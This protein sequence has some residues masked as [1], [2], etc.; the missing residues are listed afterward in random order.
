MGWPLH[1]IRLSSEPRLCKLGR[2]VPVIGTGPNRMHADRGVL[3][4]RGMLVAQHRTI[5]SEQKHGRTS[6][7]RSCSVGSISTLSSSLHIVEQGC[8]CVTLMTARGEWGDGADGR[9]EKEML[10]VTSHFCGRC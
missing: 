4:R 8:A 10:P 5:S 3:L 2:K 9:R 1:V 6:A 7:Q